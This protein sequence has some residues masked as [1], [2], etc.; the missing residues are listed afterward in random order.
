TQAQAEYL[1]ALLNSPTAQAFYR[2]FVFW[3]TKR[4]ITADLLR[5]LDLRRIAEETESKEKF[6]SLFDK[7]ERRLFV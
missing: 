3:D 1:A 7:P 6:N 2:A 5:R 4:P